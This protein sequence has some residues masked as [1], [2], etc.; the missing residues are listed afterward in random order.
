MTM[1]DALCI[2]LVGSIIL[3]VIG[4]VLIF[5]GACKYKDYDDDVE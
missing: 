2:A 4:T 1:L 3:L 5:L